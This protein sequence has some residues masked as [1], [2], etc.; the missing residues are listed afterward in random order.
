MKDDPWFIRYR[1]AGG[2][3]MVPRNAK[4]W[5]SF[6]AV[7][8]FMLLP[9]MLMGLIMPRWPW[10]VLVHL[11]IS[12]V[13]MVAFVVFAWRNAE[14]VDLRDLGRDLAEFRKWRDEQQRKR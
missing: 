11:G 4:G 8:A 3:R 9:I 2:I 6:A 1:F 13:V 5:A 7:M 12:A 14:V 10:F